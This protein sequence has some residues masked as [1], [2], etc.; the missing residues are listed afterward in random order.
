MSTNPVVD[1]SNERSHRISQSERTNEQPPLHHQF[2]WVVEVANERDQFRL[3]KKALEEQLAQLK[4]QVR[5]CNGM[6]W[7]GI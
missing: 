1:R 5:Y 2:C 6:E 4:L 7:N 3:D